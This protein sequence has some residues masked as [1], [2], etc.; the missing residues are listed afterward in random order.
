[1]ERENLIRALQAT[2]SS[3]NQKE[4]TAYL[5]QVQYLVHYYTDMFSRYI[6]G[7][8]KW[9]LNSTGPNTPFSIKDFK[10]SNQQLGS[11]STIALLDDLH[12]WQGFV[13]CYDYLEFKRAKNVVKV[14]KWSFKFSN[15]VVPFQNIRLM[16]FTPLLLHIIM[17]EG[18][19]C[20]ARQAGVIYLK[21][22]INRYLFIAVCRKS[23]VGLTVVQRFVIETKIHRNKSGVKYHHHF[24]VEI[25]LRTSDSC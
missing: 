2:T 10:K 3:T 7:Y 5:E 25:Q 14:K 24:L 16:G 21:N 12:I 1:M 19:D 13:T 22:V 4:A 23:I 9:K 11:V 18:V 20:S 17:D 8:L 6:A 15:I